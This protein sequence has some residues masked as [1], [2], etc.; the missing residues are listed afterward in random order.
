[1]RLNA[2]LLLSL[3]ISIIEVLAAH[4]VVRRMT[5]DNLAH[6][7]ECGT[8]YTLK[9]DEIMKTAFERVERE[10]KQQ[11]RQVNLNPIVFDLHVAV[12]AANM[13]YNGGWVPAKHIEDQVKVLNA[14]YLDAGVSFDLKSVRRILSRRY[15]DLLNVPETDEQ[16]IM[17]SNYGKAFRLGDVKTLN[18]N[19]IGFTTDPETYGFAL[20]PSF[21]AEFP[22]YDGA[23]IRFDSLPGGASPVRQGSTLIH[24]VGHWLSL[25]HTF[26]NG[27]EGFGDEISDTPAEAGPAT[28]CP[29]TRDSCPLQPGLDPV[30]S[31]MDYSAEGCRVRFSP[32]Q[33]D[34]MRTAIDAFRS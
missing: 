28:G 13:T 21:Y 34:R 31:Y 24:E 25:W 2:A 19:L 11:K 1:M 18:V 32:M 7:G 27:C 12:V 29:E 9:D 26:Q 3:S 20:P 10:R 23:Y 6:G 5:D 8:P 30:W 33:I 14:G 16:A 17:L 15:H 4:S 22:E